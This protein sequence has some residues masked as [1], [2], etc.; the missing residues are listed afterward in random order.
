MG[1]SVGNTTQCQQCI[2]TLTLQTLTRVPLGFPKPF[3]NT[4]YGESK[5]W[6]PTKSS[7]LNGGA[8]NKRS[9]VSTQ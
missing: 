1:F 3:T 5:N 2:L 6:Q 4:K 8:N 7:E 9:A